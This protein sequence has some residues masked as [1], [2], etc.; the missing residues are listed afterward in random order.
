ME[1]RHI[2]YFVAVAEELSFTR[3]AARLGIGQPPLSQQIKDLEAKLGVL[4]LRRVPHGAELTEPGKTFLQESR[5]VLAAAEQAAVA[6]KRAAR[7]EAGRL[8]LGFT[9]SAHFNAAVP[10][11]VRNFRRRYPDVGLHIEEANTHQLS[12][13]LTLGTLDVVF[14]RHDFT[15]EPRLSLV[16]VRTELLVAVLPS[17]H[18]C[19]NGQAV[20]V[21]ALEGDDFI[22]KSRSL[23]PVLYNAV[24]GAC[25]DAG[26]EPRIGQEAPQL[27]SVISFVAAG[28][29]V[30]LVPASMQQ[31]RADGV[32]YLPIS[33][34]QAQ[35]TLSLVWRRDERSLV[36]RHFVS[37]VK[38]VAALGPAGRGTP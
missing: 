30:S 31:I 32:A 17:S 7:G 33:D 25:R 10:L 24:V 14:S 4:L 12:E 3:A 5:L 21:S 13:L 27:A 2:K 34:V 29:G 20:P 26:F 1:L 8:R 19:A 15:N 38:E 28:L 22:V 37:I 36:A 11:V 16:P 6:A 35:V 18:R 9:G 23:G